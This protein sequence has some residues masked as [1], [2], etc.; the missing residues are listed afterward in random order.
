MVYIK[1]LKTSFS[2][3]LQ[4]RL[5]LT[6]ENLWILLEGHCLLIGRNMSQKLQTPLHKKRIYLPI[7]LIRSRIL[8]HTIAIT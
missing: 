5:D 6:T 4:H 3:L 1:T 2:N 8:G 7:G